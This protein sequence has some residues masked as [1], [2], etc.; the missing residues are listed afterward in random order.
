VREG[1]CV[2]DKSKAPAKPKKGSRRRRIGVTTLVVLGALCIFIS[3]LSIWIRDVALDPDEWA[4]TSS[5]V[6][7]SEDVRNVL[8]VYIVDQ[9]FATSD[10][11]ARLEETLPERLKPLAGPLSAQL[12]GVAYDAVARA[13]ERPRVQEL[14]RSANRAVNAQLV[15]LLEGNTERLQLTNGAV[16]LNL[17]QI[18]A[19]V[20][21]RVGAGEGA[22]TA[23]E[24]HIQ[25]IVLLE[26]DQLSSAQKAVKWLKAL[27]FWPFIVGVLLW[28]GAVYLAAGRRRPTVRNIAWSLVIMGLLILAIRRIVGHAVIDS[29]V[30]AESVRA[31]ASDVW[32]V[33]TSL[34]AQSA[35]AGI[36]VGLVTVLAMWFSGPGRRA[37]AGRRWLAPAFRDHPVIVHGTLAVVLLLFLAWGPAGTP[38]RFLAIVILVILAFVGLEI[39]RRQTVREFPDAVARDIHWPW[40]RGASSGADADRVQ[41]LER[42]A[43]LHDRGA[44]TD[45]EYEAE[46]ALLAN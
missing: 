25:P 43:A 8:S 13:L 24:G 15:D 34:L 37:T 39:L 36:F 19:N 46:K 4:N 21:G 28:A 16:V 42:L 26:S 31:A 45:E 1:R 40:R 9:T 3:T 6:L 32:T 23:L 29:L 11:E 33:L 7:Q 27:S 44:L 41:S 30:E 10:A 2:S 17:D 22:A 38:R 35:A 12:R 18:V 20:T 5:Q 14:W